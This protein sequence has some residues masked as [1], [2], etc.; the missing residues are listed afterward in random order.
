MYSFDLFGS[1]NMELKSVLP[2]K[3]KEIIN[4]K[5]EYLLVSDGNKFT[6]FTMLGKELPPK[7]YDLI[8]AFDSNYLSLTENNSTSYFLLSS[9]IYLNNQ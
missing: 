8:E 1:M 4:F 5:K 7:V 2:V 9:R 3:Y 6:L